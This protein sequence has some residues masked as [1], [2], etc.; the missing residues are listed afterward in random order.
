MQFTDFSNAQTYISNTMLSEERSLDLF[1]LKQRFALKQIDKRI[2]TIMAWQVDWHLGSKRQYT[3]IEFVDCKVFS[4][5]E[6]WAHFFEL[7]DVQRIFRRGEQLI[8][9]DVDRLEVHGQFGDPHFSYVQISVK[10]CNST[11]QDIE[12]F[13]EEE[14]NKN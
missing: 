13:D 7:E 10:A 5:D 12:C 2:G 11:A 4:D 9:P 8:C 6:N 14:L 3:P 1:K